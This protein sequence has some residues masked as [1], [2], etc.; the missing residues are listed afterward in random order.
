MSKYPSQM[1][2]KFN[3][4]FPEGMRDAI[5]KRAKANSRSMN[6]EIVQ[7]IEDAIRQKTQSNEVN[8]GRIKTLKIDDIS[9]TDDLAEAL[10]KLAEI[11][12]SKKYKKPS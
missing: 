7:I 5:A 8:S 10:K 9:S 6:S 1:Q 3:L 2:D 4:R 12:E 11:V